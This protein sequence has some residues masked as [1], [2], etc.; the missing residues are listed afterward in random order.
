MVT[1]VSLANKMA[2]VGSSDDLKCTQ[3]FEIQGLIISLIND[4]VL[5]MALYGC[6]GKRMTDKRA[7]HC[8]EGP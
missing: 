1:C 3:N 4:L 8:Q 6:L 2:S 5:Y 7:R